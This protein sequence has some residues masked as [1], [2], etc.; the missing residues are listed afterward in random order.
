MAEFDPQVEGLQEKA[1]EMRIRILKML[2][3]AK[4]GH[5]GGSLSAVAVDQ[6]YCY[7]HWIELFRLEKGKVTN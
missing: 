1:R 3:E 6:R 7:P 4:S 2:T 5:T